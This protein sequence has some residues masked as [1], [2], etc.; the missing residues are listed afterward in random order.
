MAQRVHAEIV[1]NGNA[2]VAAV[3]RMGPAARIQTQVAVNRIGAIK[4]VTAATAEA[5]S[6]VYGITAEATEAGVYRLDRQDT[7]MA[8]LGEEA[9]REHRVAKENLRRRQQQV[10][11]Q[12][13]SIIQDQFWNDLEDIVCQPDSAFYKASLGERLSAWFWDDT[14]IE[15]QR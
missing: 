4:G 8:R 1:E 9:A 10:A 14:S 3:S 15:L 5:L 2:P 12:A 6:G 7:L 13:A 11:E